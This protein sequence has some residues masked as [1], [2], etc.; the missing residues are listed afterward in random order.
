MNSTHHRNSIASANRRQRMTNK[1]EVEAMA[2]EKHASAFY[3]DELN[4]TSHNSISELCVKQTTL[5]KKEMSKIQI[6]RLS[7]LTQML[8]I[9]RSCVYDWLNPRSPRYDPSF[10]KQVR[11]TGRNSGGA[12]GWRLDSVMAWLDSR[13]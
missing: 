7:Q 2:A 11:L 10:P 6:I 4:K 3:Q 9:S 12:V 1:H 13:G 5:H 8:S